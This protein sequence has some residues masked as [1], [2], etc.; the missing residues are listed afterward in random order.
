M[1]KTVI[2]T[3]FCFDIFIREYYLTNESLQRIDDL[4]D[5]LLTIDHD[6]YWKHKGETEYG[7]RIPDIQ[8]V[9][10]FLNTLL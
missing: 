8:L 9:G 5:M 4:I 3:E 1:L 6:T 10:E 2:L 7:Q